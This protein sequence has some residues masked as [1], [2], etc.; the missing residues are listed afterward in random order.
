MPQLFQTIYHSTSSGPVSRPALEE[1]AR[2]A[3]ERNAERELTGVLLYGWQNFVQ[4][5]EGTADRTFELLGRIAKDR[6]CQTVQVHAIRPVPRRTYDGWAMQTW[7]VQETDETFRITFAQL[8]L[9]LQSD[10]LTPDERIDLAIKHI[11]EI[12]PTFGN[13]A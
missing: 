12:K 10:A 2:V 13:A 8:L 6:R 9:E 3:G 4:L 5:L 1:L 7:H 11:E